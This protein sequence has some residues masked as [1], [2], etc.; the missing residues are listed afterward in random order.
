MYF[1]RAPDPAPFIRVDVCHGPMRQKNRILGNGC[2]TCVLSPN[3]IFS[4]PFHRREMLKMFFGFIFLSQN[5][6]NNDKS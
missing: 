5:H 6:N 4:Y 1:G 3:V 2:Q